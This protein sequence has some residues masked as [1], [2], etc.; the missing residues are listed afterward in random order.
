[1]VLEHASA[2]EPLHFFLRGIYADSIANVEHAGAVRGEFAMVRGVRQV[3]P[4]SSYLFTMALDPI[5]RWLLS[6]AI[7][8]EP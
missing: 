8:P 6:S 3:C 5:F 2:P 4:A 1:M 7:P